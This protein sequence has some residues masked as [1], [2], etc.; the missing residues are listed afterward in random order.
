MS[1]RKCWPRDWAEVTQVALLCFAEG[2]GPEYSLETEPPVP[3]SGEWR[4]EFIARDQSFAEARLI[5]NAM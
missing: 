4:G 2:Q 5:D 3:Q 1:R